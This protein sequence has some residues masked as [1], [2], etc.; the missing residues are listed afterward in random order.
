MKEYE[1]AFKLGAELESS[2]RKTFA[3][4]SERLEQIDKQLQGI[5]KENSN[6]SKSTKLTNNLSKAL[7][8]G[9]VGAATAA[10]G[11]MT[12][13]GAAAVKSVNVFADFEQGM[14]NVKAVSGVAGAEFDALAEKAKELGA[15]TSKTA[16]E[17]AEGLEYLALA[18]W[19]TE[20]ML[21]GIE[22]VLRLSEAGALD[23]GYASDLVTG[24]MSALGI[25]V[26]DLNGYLD[27]V[28]QTSRR[29]NTNIDALMEAFLVAGGTFSTFNVPL[30]EANALLGVL[31]NRGFKG[32]EAGTALNAII[33][34]LTSGAG[35]AGKALDELGISAFDSQGNFK[36]LENTLEEIRTRMESMTDAEKAQYIAMI[37]GKEHL[38]TF[39][40]LLDGLGKEYASLKNDVADSTGALQEM[41]DVKMD[42]LQGSF[43]KLRSAFESVQLAIGERI[44]PYVRQFADWMTNTIPT[45]VTKAENA[46]ARISGIVKPI[47]NTISKDAKTFVKQMQDSDI[48]A[49]WIDGW[50]E[51]FPFVQE[52]FQSIVKIIKKSIPVFVS[53]GKTVGKVAKQIISFLMPI[54]RYISSKLWTIINKVFKFISDDV[55]PAIANAVQTYLPQIE[56]IFSG[57]IDG[58]SLVWNVVKPAIDR[59]VESFMTA[60]PLI[61]DVVMDTIRAIKGV[62]SGLLQTLGGVIDFIVGVFSGDWERAWQG[63]KDIFGGVFKGLSSLLAWPLNAVISL[64]NAAIREINKINIDIPDWVPDFG[65][66]SFG[67]DIPEIPKLEG[68]ADGGFSNRPAIFG[69]AGLEAAIPIDNRPRSH[70]LL[71]KVNQMMGHSGGGIVINAPFSPNITI[72]SGGDVKNQVKEGINQAFEEWKRNMKR[73]LQ[74]ERRLS[75]NG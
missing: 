21:T 71:D 19:N 24:S 43:K 5:T 75:F 18:G 25:Q 54:A 69:E 36:G 70:A 62:I 35:Q 42:T 68:F 29:S 47:F 26:Q 53:I 74:E 67:F 46:F 64:I 10:A 4:A 28:A 73:F 38:K 51:I 32:S 30:E 37:A 15:N 2:F 33:T 1:L 66:E 14:A 61:K 57:L 59:T 63:V 20:Q 40:G 34:N 27:Q 56:H 55:F 13:L 7:K 44:A 6:L 52:T 50:K 9:L 17:A 41:A 72:N 45:A 31:A 12:A 39:T 11:A 23:L 49:Y 65:G 48:T 3:S 60:W 16:A 8:V 58:L 22:P